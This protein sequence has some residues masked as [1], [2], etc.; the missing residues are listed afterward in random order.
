MRQ[1]IIKLIFGLPIK[2]KPVD[3]N[4]CRVNYSIIPKE[5]LQNYPVNDALTISSN[6]II[7]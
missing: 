5:Y 4:R 6:R 7:I 2:G 1:L 3:L